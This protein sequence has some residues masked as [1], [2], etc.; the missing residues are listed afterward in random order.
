MNF[1]RLRLRTPIYWSSLNVVNGNLT[2]YYTDYRFI[3]NWDMREACK[4]KKFDDLPGLPSIADV[5]K[6]TGSYTKLWIGD[7]L[8]ILAPKEVEPE[9]WTCPSGKPLPREHFWCWY[10]DENSQRKIREQFQ[11]NLFT[12]KRRSSFF[13]TLVPM[14]LQQT[15]SS[16]LQ[17]NSIEALRLPDLISKELDWIFEWDG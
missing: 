13:K 6:L 3:F 17:I 10:P 1:H 9:G 15:H 16:I 12:S 7:H 5:L 14:Q 11:E 2:S 8:G 4:Q